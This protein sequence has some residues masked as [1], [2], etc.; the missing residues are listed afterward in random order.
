MKKFFIL[1]LLICFSSQCVFALQFDSSIDSDIRKNYNV[2]ELPKLP[3]VEPTKVEAKKE[4]TTYNITGKTYTIPSGTKIILIS[5][6]KISN[7]SAQGSKFSLLSQNQITTKEGIIIPSGSLF[8]GTITNSH[9]PQITGNGGLIEL[10]ID[11]IY[12]NGLNSAIDTKVTLVN[13][14]KVFKGKLKGQ[15]KYLKNCIKA[16]KPGQKT[17]R[18]MKKAANVLLPYPIVNILSLVPLTIGTTTFLVNAAFSPI[19]SIFMKGGSISIPEGTA[20]Y[21]IIKGNNQIRG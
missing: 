3:N 17:F 13:S 16:V 1:L 15:R 11:E 5:K 2:E 20:F 10:K 6:D 19:I 9:A 14:K 7:W 12:Y 8:K 18:V 21:V 4:I